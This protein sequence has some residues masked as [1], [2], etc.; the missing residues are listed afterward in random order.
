MAFPPAVLLILQLLHPSTIPVAPVDFRLMPSGAVVAESG[1]TGQTDTP[2][3][4]T[5]IAQTPTRSPA[6][7]PARAARPATLQ[8]YGTDIPLSFAVRQIVPRGIR[9]IYGPGATPET[10]VSW[11]GGKAWYDVLRD[12]LKPRR[13]RLLLAGQT[14]TIT[15]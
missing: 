12:S 15:R 4:N 1:H 5:D 7:P 3:G 10:P 6:P 13:L 11:T 14:A 9:V 2:H 8:G